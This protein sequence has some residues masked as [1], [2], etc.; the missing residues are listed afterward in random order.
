[1]SFAWHEIRDHLMHSSTRLPFQRSFEAVRR[2]H[3]AL[4]GF[5]DPAALLDVLHGT[6]GDPERK[7]R[8]L[9]AL[10]GAAQGK[11]P[12]SDCALTLLLLAL[13]P[14]LDAARGRLRRQVRGREDELS[15]MI[16]AGASE[17]IRRMDLAAVS[18]IA[19]TTIRNVERDVRRA[20]VAERQRAS[21]TDP[22]EEVA[23]TQGPGAAEAGMGLD[24]AAGLAALGKDAALVHA[25]SV[26]G[27]TRRE[28]GARLGLGEAA[29]RKRHQRAIARLRASR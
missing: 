23:E 3:A 21:V 14:G 11:G 2:S 1:M 28:A 18:R 24:L 26:E 17:R 12:A 13:W 6:P 19:A 22:V 4:A 27:L 10:V 5:R 15:A 9:R 20:L 7:N 29:A 16:L 8:A 25:V